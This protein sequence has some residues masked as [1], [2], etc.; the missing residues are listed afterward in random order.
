MQ[1]VLAILY[2]GKFSHGAKFCSFVDRSA[3]TKIRTTKFSSAKY[4]LLVGVVL[5]ER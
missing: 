1:Q 5:P 2:S 4:G 3:A